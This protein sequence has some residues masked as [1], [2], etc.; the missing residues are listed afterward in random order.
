MTL[1]PAIVDEV[2]RL[3]GEDKLSQRRIA[4]QLG[5]GRNTVDAIATGKR[6]C[7]KVQ[8]ISDTALPD[9]PYIRCP[10]CGGK[11]QIPCRVCRTRS[12]MKKG[13]G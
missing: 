6:P 9:G 3:L 8:R 11:Q 2:K 1:A 5:V 10:G 4:R 7:R 12:Q 13:G